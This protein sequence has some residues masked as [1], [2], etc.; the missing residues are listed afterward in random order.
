MSDSKL[1]VSDR[2]TTAPPQHVSPPLHIVSSLHERRR[3]EG[4][5]C[6]KCPNWKVEEEEGAETSV[7]MYDR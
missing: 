6:P 1:S 2:T 5:K 3:E 4:G 7:G